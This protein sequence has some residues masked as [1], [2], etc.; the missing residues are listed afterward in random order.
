LL[1]KKDSPQKSKKFSRG[2]AETQRGYLRDA[3]K[4]KIYRQGMGLF[5]FKMVLSVL[6]VDFFAPSAALRETA[7]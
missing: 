1:D 7:V 4:F 3:S 6:G 2:V 5:I